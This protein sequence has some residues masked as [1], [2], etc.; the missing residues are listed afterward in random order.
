MQSSCELLVL[1]LG[2]KFA[3]KSKNSVCFLIL[4]QSKQFIV[5]LSDSELIEFVSGRGSSR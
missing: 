5:V 1:S 4:L 2:F 3:I